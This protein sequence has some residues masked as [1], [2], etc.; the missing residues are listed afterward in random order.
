MLVSVWGLL[1]A[2]VLAHMPVGQPS[3]RQ[4]SWLAAR[5]GT[6]VGSRAAAEARDMPRISSHTHAAPAAAAMTRSRTMTML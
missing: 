2:L 4:A 6:L 5:T 3:L 1:T